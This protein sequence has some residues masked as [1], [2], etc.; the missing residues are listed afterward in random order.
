[1]SILQSATS[2]M[3]ADMQEAPVL[4][5][6]GVVTIPTAFD[7]DTPAFV[8]DGTECESP[9][10]AQ[11]SARP[12]FEGGMSKRAM[13]MSRTESMARTEADLDPQL[14]GFAAA[15]EAVRALRACHS[16]SAT[17]A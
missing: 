9:F 11:S 8:A 2:W 5:S 3:A 17:C 14:T 7:A 15:I 16:A 10:T 1:M 6:A 13:S 12:S 4:R